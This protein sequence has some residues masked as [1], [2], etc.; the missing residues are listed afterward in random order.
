MRKLIR[1]L[2]RRWNDVWNRFVLRMRRKALILD[3]RQNFTPLETR[4]VLA[5]SAFDPGLGALSV[6]LDNGETATLTQNLDQFVLDL[7]G[8]SSDLSGSI[9]DLLRIEVAGVGPGNNGTFLWGGSSNNDFSLVSQINLSVQD[10]L[11]T[12]VNVKAQEIIIQGDSSSSSF[13]LINSGIVQITPGGPFNFTDTFSITTTD[14]LADI[15]LDGDLRATSSATSSDVTFRTLG[16]DA[17][18]FI[19]GDIA[20]VGDPSTTPNSTLTIETLGT[21]G[22]LGSNVSFLSSQITT[23]DDATVVSVRALGGSIDM[24]PSSSINAMDGT[25]E[26]Q[27][28]TSIRFTGLSST[29]TD[30]QAIRVISLTGELIGADSPGNDADATNGGILLNAVTGIGNSDAL[31]VKV[32]VLS[33]T[34]STSGRISLNNQ[35]SPGDGDLTLNIVENSFRE[36][37]IFNQFSG[38]Q[39]SPTGR[40]VGN[41]VTLV[42]DA[43]VFDL[44][45][46]DTPLRTSLNKS[47]V[48]TNSTNA[49]ASFFGLA[50]GEIRLTTQSDL[51]LV[52]LRALESVLS[53]P[54]I[55]F[56]STPGINQIVIESLNSSITQGSGSPSGILTH[57]LSATAS[58]GSVTLGNVSNN[59]QF[60]TG[61]SQGD[62]L[63]TDANGFEVR[64][65]NS[66]SGN[67]TL[68]AQ[69]GSILQASGPT[70]AITASRVSATASGGSVTLDNVS[71]NAQFVT[72]SSQDDFLYTDANGFEVR[73][74]NSSQG[75]IAIATVA[76]SITQ[77]LSPSDGIIANKL[78]VLVDTESNPTPNQ[79][80]IDG[81]GR[82]SILLNSANNDV[83]QVEAVASGSIQ[84]VNKDS[85]QV[86]RIAAVAKDFV[87]GSVVSGVTAANE[88]VLVSREGGVSQAYSP[89]APNYEALQAHT[90]RA[91]VTTYAIFPDIDVVRLNVTPQ[92]D[93]VLSNADLNTVVGDIFDD[94]SRLSTVYAAANAS[95]TKFL[96]TLNVNNPRLAI[97]NELRE[98]YS[99]DKYKQSFSVLVLNR[100]DLI[101]DGI[102]A[103]GSSVSGLP[104][105]FSAAPNFL[106]ASVASDASVV[107]PASS[108]DLLIAAGSR[109]EGLSLDKSSRDNSGLVLLAG[110]NL[111]FEK[112]GTLPIGQIGTAPILAQSD[113]VQTVFSTDLAAKFNNGGKG[114]QNILS[115]EFVIGNES[116]NPGENVRTHSQQRVALDFGNIDRPTAGT[117]IQE[118]GFNVIVSYFDGATQAFSSKSQQ[119][120]SPPM[121]TNTI[122]EPVHPLPAIPTTNIAMM[123]SDSMDLQNN[124]IFQRTVP[125]SV[126]SALMFSM[127]TPEKTLAT[128]A[129]VRRS[130]DFFMFENV[131]SAFTDPS[132][133][134][135]VTFQNQYIDNV[136]P[137]GPSA[138]MMDPNPEMQMPQIWNGEMMNQAEILPLIR[139]DKPDAEIKAAQ[140]T[141]EIGVWSIGYVDENKNG[142]V[143]AGDSEDESQ[144]S[145]S[146]DSNDPLVRIITYRIQEDELLEGIQQETIQRV[147]EL[148]KDSKNSEDQVVEGFNQGGGF[149]AVEFIDGAPAEDTRRTFLITK[150]DIDSEIK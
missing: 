100:G 97:T 61:S 72:G 18:I 57:S 60:I 120:T 54:S 38:I 126:S 70:D 44:A 81:W 66:S 13:T 27:A 29:S 36:I 45:N 55:G 108:G 101:V 12:D 34:N 75:K 93:K 122:K 82:N 42:A 80:S 138:S 7:P 49:I 109:I 123:S 128:N 39:Q 46:L 148:I 117:S 149:V 127:L 89:V 22:A 37:E 56:Q 3:L 8:T 5:S 20:L 99:L 40:I 147:V 90:L 53:G 59:A 77:G 119:G 73:G 58:G 129:I 135:D 145:N 142:M 9:A 63:F 143:D 52:A 24:D 65:I 124:A 114:S 23:T 121:P 31:D 144:A 92:K 16:S 41:Q 131:N 84:F 4:Q 136:K 76:G 86:G 17:S 14:S 32:G 79:I 85:F 132:G 102:K 146:I 43:S 1:N 28:N 130:S 71:N 6:Q 33:A 50:T 137:L 105:N 113:Q 25:I 94:G 2:G 103:V 30:V 98:A 106:I 11:S 48:L 111:V 91:T 88:V 139:Q 19:D 69:S 115:T 141:V 118:Q 47:I 15:R 125:A 68:A 140:R 74:I 64:G 95:A 51:N 134:R 67:A 116:I 10:L 133:V 21:G 83:G 110:R 87:A 150:D 35:S 62:F 26:F 96:D 104:S 78:S 112:S 107:K